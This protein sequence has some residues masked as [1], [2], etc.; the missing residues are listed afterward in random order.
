MAL[1]NFYITV[2]VAMVST[3]SAIDDYWCKKTTQEVGQ[4]YS[5]ACPVGYKKAHHARGFIGCLVESGQMHHCCVPGCR[6]TS[7]QKG[8]CYQGSSCPSGYRENNFISKRL[9]CFSVGGAYSCCVP[10]AVN[11]TVSPPLNPVSQDCG[12]MSKSGR[13]LG[14]GAS[15][16]GKCTW[17]WMVS[18]RSR[19]DAAT[20]AQ[21]VSLSNTLQLAS[22]VLIDSQ[23]V[24][25]TAYGLSLAGQGVDNNVLNNIFLVASEHNVNTIEGDELFLTAS[26][27]F[28]H[29]QSPLSGGIRALDFQGDK[30][31][32]QGGNFALIKLSTPVTYSQCV[33]KAC[34]NKDLNVDGNCGGSQCYIAGWGVTTDE[35]FP[36]VPYGAAVDVFNNVTCQT[37]AKYSGKTDY[38]QQPY[39][40]CASGL[41]SDTRPCVGDNGGMV[42]CN[43]K[44]RWAVRGL[45]TETTFEC[46]TD[47]PFIISDL[48]AVEDWI[49]QTMANN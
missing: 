43:Q 36:S 13:V 46:Q 3:S 14:S 49:T 34:L 47:E 28:I 44:G 7:Q 45:I 6:Y 9:G 25:T 42:V 1:L 35:P 19:S 18:I 40:M 41:A 39:T 12:L 23:W 32:L 17:P 33:K 27:Y 21:P 26:K 31:L 15:P 16:I 8:Q 30:S 2:A 20:S 22:G 4:C 48:G 29:P 10:K 38:V 37:I 24:I 11:A 5:G